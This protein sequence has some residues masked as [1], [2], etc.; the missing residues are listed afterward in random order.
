MEIFGIKIPLPEFLFGKSDKADVEKG[1]EDLLDKD[2]DLSPAKEVLKSCFFGWSLFFFG[3]IVAIIVAALTIATYHGVQAL[4]APKEPVPIRTVNHGIWP[5]YRHEFFNDLVSF[6]KAES[7]CSSR[8]STLL[9]FANQ[10]QE[11]QFD[12]YVGKNF[13]DQTIYPDYL[14]WT[15]GYVMKR[16]TGVGGAATGQM[17]RWPDKDMTRTDTRNDLNRIRYCGG[18]VKCMNQERCDDAESAYYFE[19]NIVKDYVDD[20]LYKPDM[21]QLSENETDLIQGCWQIIRR[22]DVKPEFF[23]RFVCQSKIARTQLQI[24]N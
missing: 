23:F 10:Q 19:A 14:L 5:D 15:R 16:K 11:D 17:I 7:V 12:M 4:L 9:S 2:G 3:L 21:S 1:E 18:W 22:N 8:N 6:I 20:H 24:T 13:W